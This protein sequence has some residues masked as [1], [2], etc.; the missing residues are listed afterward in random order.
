MNDTAAIPK[1]PRPTITATTI[2]MIFRALLFLGAAVIVA[3]TD[4][5]GEADDALPS[6]WVAPHLVQNFAPPS[7]VAP[8]ELQNAI[9]FASRPIIFALTAEYIASSPHHA[10]P[11]H[12]WPLGA[13]TKAAGSSSLPGS[14]PAA[15]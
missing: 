10:W 4:E 5:E 11:H 7:K 12:A 6:G 2:R 14:N 9:K 15:A 1:I 8:Q 13:S 3:G